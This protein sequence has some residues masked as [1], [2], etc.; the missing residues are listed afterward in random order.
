MIVSP[1]LGTLALAF[2]KC[3]KE[4]KSIGLAI[5]NFNLLKIMRFK[6]RRRRQQSSQLPAVNLIPMLNVMIAVLGF[7]VVVSTSLSNEQGVKVDLPSSGEG[8]G[9]KASGNLPDPLVIR[10]NKD[11]ILI[12]NQTATEQQALVEAKA[13]LAK[14]Q[15]GN[16]LLS[17]SDEVPY[18]EVIK[19]LGQL[20]KLD[21]KRVALG[22]E[23]DNQSSTKTQ[24]EDT[25]EDFDD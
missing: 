17:A 25:E 15:K 6:T 20:R 13:Y 19:L 12:N 24:Q 14:N 8:A 3:K 21:E 11:Q 5:T 1:I 7:F 18:E 2:V 10:R 22:F 4:V 23:P 9:D 16:V